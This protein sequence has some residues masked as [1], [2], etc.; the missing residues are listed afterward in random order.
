MG[1]RKPPFLVQPSGILSGVQD[2]QI[3]R[4]HLYTSFKIWSD[5]SHIHVGMQLYCNCNRYYSD[6]GINAMCLKPNQPLSFKDG[7]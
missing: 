5:E 1:C 6:V 4:N 3:P 2:P 7:L